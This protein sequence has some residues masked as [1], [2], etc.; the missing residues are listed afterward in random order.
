MW[1]PA[2]S[3]SLICLL[4][5]AS[6]G[7]AQTKGPYG[8]KGPTVGQ[9]EPVGKEGRASGLGMWGG[10]PGRSPLSPGEQGASEVRPLSQGSAAPQQ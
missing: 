3:Q 8:P 2:P 7:A 4:H 9:A 6:W 1:G 10:F 5:R